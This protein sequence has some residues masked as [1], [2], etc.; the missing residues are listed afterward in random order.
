[1]FPQP[2]SERDLLDFLPVMVAEHVAGDAETPHPGVE[3]TGRY[4]PRIRPERKQHLPEQISGVLREVYS[5]LQVQ[6]KVVSVLGYHN[7]DPLTR[8]GRDIPCH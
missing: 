7:P 8:R 4:S 1:M 6:E 5:P 2:I 3:I